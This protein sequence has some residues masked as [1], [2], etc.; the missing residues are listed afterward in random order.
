MEARRRKEE[1]ERK[2]QEEI[3]RKNAVSAS[4][5][6]L[7]VQLLLANDICVSKRESS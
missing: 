7:T 3:D 6:A 4:S 1:E 2:K 5:L